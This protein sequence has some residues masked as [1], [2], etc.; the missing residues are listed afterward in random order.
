MPKTDRQTDEAER[1]E[2]LCV[3]FWMLAGDHNLII[4]GGPEENLYA[5][6]FLDGV[7]LTVENGSIMIL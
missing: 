7:P 6:R 5:Q 2:F 3:M 4:L 1:V